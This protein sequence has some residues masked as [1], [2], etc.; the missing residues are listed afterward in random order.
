MYE[1]VYVIVK[2]MIKEF[3]LKRDK[4]IVFLFCT[5]PLLLEFG[6]LKCTHTHTRTHAR[7]STHTH[8]HI[9][10]LRSAL[11]QILINSLQIIHQFQVDTLAAEMMLLCVNC[12]NG[13]HIKVRRN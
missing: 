1:Y 10:S 12:S 9:H 2:L 11:N 8:T 3:A 4:K 6:R 5:L 7:A 13:S